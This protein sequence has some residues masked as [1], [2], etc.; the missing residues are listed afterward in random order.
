MAEQKIYFQW[1][2]EV[3]EKTIY[4]LRL[5]KLRH[6]LEYYM[7]IDLW[8]EYKDKKPEDLADDITRYH[9][10]KKEVITRA[11]KDFNDL[12]AYF[13]EAFVPQVEPAKPVDEKVLA[14]VTSL[15]N[16]FKMYFLSI[17]DARKESY[18]ISQ[19]LEELDKARI[20]LDKDIARQMRYLNGVKSI[21]NNPNLTKAI[22]LLAML[23]N[24]KPILEAERIQLKELVSAHEKLAKRKMDFAKKVGVALKQQKDIE[25]RLNPLRTEI[26]RKDAKL[27]EI[28]DDIHRLRTQPDRASTEKYFSTPDVSDQIRQRFQETDAEMVKKVN[29]IHA[30]LSGLKGDAVKLSYLKNH[31]F[32]LQVEKTRFERRTGL[33]ATFRENTLQAFDDELNRLK[34]FKAVLENVLTPPAQQLQ[35]LEAWEAEKARVEG[36]LS[37]VRNE[38]DGLLKQLDELDDILFVTQDKY[39]SEYMPVQPTLKEIV[40]LKLED[41]KASLM[42]K[43]QYELLK[44]IVKRFKDEPQRYPRWLQYMIIHFSGMRYASAHG[45]WAD[46]KDLYIN[47]RTSRIDSDLK[48]M[49]DYAIAAL[50]NQK[51]DWY[52]PPKIATLTLPGS[53][54]EPPKLA[55]VRDAKWKEKVDRQLVRIRSDNAYLRRIGLFNLMLDEANYEV[56]NITAAEALAQLELI[57]ATLPEWMWNEISA[58]TDLRLKEA[59]DATWEKLTPEQQQERNSAEWAKYREIMNKWK[60]DHLTGWRQEHEHNVGVVVSRAVCNEVAEFIQHLRGHKGGAG[61]ASKPDWYR[62]EE[63]KYNASPNKKPEDDHPY[64]LKPRKVEDYHVGASILWVQYRSDQSK[65]WNAVKDFTT[66]GGDRLV[67]NEYLG[68]RAETGKWMYMAGGVERKRTFMNERK[69]PLTTKQSLYWLH[70]ATVAEVAET[71][72]GKVV[73]TFETALPYEDRRLSS[74]GLFKHYDYNILYDGGEDSYN[75]SFVGYVPEN[76]AGIQNEDLDDMLNWD[77]VLLEA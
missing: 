73:L 10:R 43:D 55:A 9:T 64:F 52:E 69:R 46:P 33:Q 21:P 13:M 67:P 42:D 39:I 34:D 75:G 3:L 61:L 57:K 28:Q 29:A 48:Q 63:N 49:D 22:Q 6:V 17:K 44:L 14:K 4:P 19:R 8:K 18:F 7:E 70:E 62:G 72:E 2:N 5:M 36:P 35:M 11:V 54:V 16:T 37:R 15:H 40:L 68:R 47:L 59:K 71:A 31:V 12:L 58:V 26:S 41:Y 56:E 51:L 77:H 30:N 74:V 60:Q 66:S 38:A 50:C 23:Q 1:Q 25:T 24:C 65:P 76:K 45:S 27:K 53:K 32:N 20:Q